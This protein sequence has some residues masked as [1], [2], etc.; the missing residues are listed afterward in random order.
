MFQ[1]LKLVVTKS[2]NI[3]Y[4]VST[5]F[6]TAL[7]AFLLFYLL[8]CNDNGVGPV[9]ELTPLPDDAAVY[10]SMDGTE[11]G[12]WILN[13][14]S[15]ELIDSM[16][17]APGVPWTIEFSPDYNSWYSCWGTSGDY[18]IYTCNFQ[19]LTIQNRFQ[20]Q[21]AKYA[22]VKSYDGKHLIAYGYK[23]IDIFDRISLSL[24]HRICYW[25]HLFFYVM[26]ISQYRM[27]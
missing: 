15:L 13:P 6:F 19:P 5:V 11:A 20:L 3:L 1:S 10:L 4:K 21:D 17:T 7:I 12:L 26:I 23:G 22:L 8:S 24:D 16:I 2:R 25:L 27:F 9:S 14:N 18:S